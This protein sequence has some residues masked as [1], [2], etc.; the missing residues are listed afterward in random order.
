M[1]KLLSLG[2]A[3]ALIASS[4]GVAATPATAA[5][6]RLVSATALHTYATRADVDAALTADKFDPGTDR[7]GVR[8]YRLVYRTTDATGK[9]TT[10]SGLVALPINDRVRLDTASFAHGTSI[11]KGDAPS[12]SDDV[13]LIGPAL[14]FASAGFAAVA[15][16]YLGL[17]VG[18]GAHPWMDIP[19]E[20]TAS[21]DLLRAARVF[22][23]R[24]GRQ[25]SR[26]VY[27]SGFSQGASAALGL[28]RALQSG[29]DPWFRA[30]A[31]API[32]G[33]Y[34]FRHAEIPA[35]FTPAV[36]P[37]L[38]SAY[39]TYLLAAYDRLHDIYA[40]PADVFQ[41]PYVGLP[42]LFDGTHPGEEIIPALPPTID[43][44]L[45]PRGKA[46]LL[47]PTGRF[48]KALAV[49]DSVCTDWDPAMPVRLY[50]SPGDEEAVN[51]N[52]AHCH[53]TLGAPTVNVGVNTTYNGFVHEG[54]EVL[55]VPRVTRWFLDHVL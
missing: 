17:G 4:L 27:A 35:L 8:T 41:P 49:A 14:T 28:G 2:I 45:T 1:R 31:V 43:A 20:T 12:V 40:D 46:L 33:A 50:Y 6:G 11:Y 44:L 42:A 38:A 7:Y 24:Q 37:V 51:A 48:A 26:D 30:A 32:S 18:P 16:D 55:A 13:F 23:A 54:S 3:G 9:P 25:L 10:A 36:H 34:D 22:V 19:S 39:T 5:N 53:A 47:H 29:A 21:L 15:P 52:T